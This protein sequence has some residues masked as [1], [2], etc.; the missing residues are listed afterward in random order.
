MFQTMLLLAAVVSAPPQAPVPPQAPA[1]AKPRD[2][3]HC[4]DYA[5]LYR[6][7]ES[8]VYVVL[9]VGVPDA[10]VGRYTPH[11]SAPSGFRGLADGIYD[12]RRDAATG[13][14]MMTLRQPQ[15]VAPPPPAPVVWQNYVPPVCVGG[16]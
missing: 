14:V 13:R 4:R 8:G 11:W 15:R 6:L 10:S 16:T 5:E 9:Y 2:P 12:C 1:A 3:N 7:A